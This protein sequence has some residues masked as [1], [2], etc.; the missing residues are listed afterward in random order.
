MSLRGEAYLDLIG[1]IHDED[2]G[3]DLI[4]ITSP[5]G[6]Q[7]DFRALSNDIHLSI[8]PGTGDVVTGRQASV[9]VLIS[10]LIASGFQDIRGI[11]DSN[12]RP[13][14]VTAVDAND[15]STNFKVIESH[16][17]RGMGSMTLFLETYESE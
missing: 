9:T 4:T 16:P 6:S 7:E 2:T 11:P 5:D 13:W 10:D 3:G 15:V 12:S 8:D 17:D 1:I 14:V